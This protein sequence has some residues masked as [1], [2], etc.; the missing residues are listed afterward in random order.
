MNRHELAATLDGR[1]YR[2]E[3]SRVE[4]I[5]AKESG[6]VVVFGASDDL[7]EFRG[8]VNDEIGVY[9]GGVAHFTRAG[10]LT[11]ECDNEDCPFFA[12]M[13]NTATTIGA[14]WD[15]E[16]YSWVYETTIPHSTFDILED[17]EKYCRGV[18]FALSDAA[19][20]SPTV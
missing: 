2:D 5:L 16:G 3:M 20:L 15:T 18:V 17:D 4:E 9:E 14:K 7:M 1:Q 10:L 12:K 13:K 11:N 19:P 8:A 6:L